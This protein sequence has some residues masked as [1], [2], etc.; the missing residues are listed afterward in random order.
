MDAITLFGLAL[1]LAM[2]AF[3]VAISVAAGLP[4]L[5]SRHIFRLAW[6]F[7]LFQAMLPVI[8]WVGGTAVSRLMMSIDHWIAF[9]LLSFLGLRMINHARTTD[10]WKTGHDPTKGWSLVGLSLATSIDAFAVGISFFVFCR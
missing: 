1:A 6:H 4:R 10:E 9:G 5:T 2:D 3:A 7:G 8:G